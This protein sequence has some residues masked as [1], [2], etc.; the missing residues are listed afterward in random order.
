MLPATAAGNWTLVQSYPGGESERWTPCQ[1]AN[2]FETEG[3]RGR[4]APR[5]FRFVQNNLT[6]HGRWWGCKKRAMDP[7]SSG[8]V[9]PPLEDFRNRENNLTQSR[10]RADQGRV[11]ASAAKIL[12]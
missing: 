10:P 8:A 9:G 4:R 5:R 2:V 11:V 12:A 6:H 7:M 1:A 3:G